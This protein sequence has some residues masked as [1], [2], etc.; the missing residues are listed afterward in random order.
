MWYDSTA[1]NQEVSAKVPQERG[2]MLL[3]I[4]WI[5]SDNKNGFSASNSMICWSGSEDKL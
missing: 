3:L 2:E 1:L 5:K 4:S